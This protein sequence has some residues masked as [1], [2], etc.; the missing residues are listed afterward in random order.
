MASALLLLRT[1]KAGVV[2]RLATIGVSPVAEERGA[3]DSVPHFRE[4]Q[5][6]EIQRT[7]GRVAETESQG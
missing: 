5:R 4:A 6:A 1:C 3:R 2:Q 7:E